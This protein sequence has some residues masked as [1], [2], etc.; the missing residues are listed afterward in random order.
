VIAMAHAIGDGQPY[1]AA[2]VCGF[3]KARLF[4]WIRGTRRIKLSPL[5]ALCAASGSDLVPAMR[6]QPHAQVRRSFRYCLSPA[7]ISISASC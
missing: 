1:R 4:D 3:N 7:Q 2:S 5:L 6:G